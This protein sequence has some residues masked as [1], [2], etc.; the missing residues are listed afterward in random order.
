[1][2]SASRSGV[3]SNAV[4]ATAGAGR[5]RLAVAHPGPRSTAARPVGTAPEAVG[6]LTARPRALASWAYEGSAGVGSR[7]LRIV[8]DGFAAV[9]LDR[10][11]LTGR[12]EGEA[13]IVL[14]PLQP[15]QY[16]YSVQV[17]DAAGHRSNIL[18]ASFTLLAQPAGAPAPCSEPV[19]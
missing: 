4:P 17:E 9:A 13:E 2:T 11:S 10:S 12:R 15:G 19:R 3:R 7:Q 6:A 8:Q 16:R 5:E 18:E 1:V 14:T